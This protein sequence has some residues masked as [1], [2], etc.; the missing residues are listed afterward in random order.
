M[1]IRIVDD[2]EDRDRY[3]WISALLLLVLLWGLAEWFKALPRWGQVTVLM[4][5]LG[6]GLWCSWPRDLGGPVATYTSADVIS[7]CRQGIAQC[8]P[9]WVR[10]ESQPSASSAESSASLTPASSQPTPVAASSPPVAPEVSVPSEV[11]TTAGTPRPVTSEPSLR[12]TMAPDGSTAPMVNQTSSPSQPIGTN[13]APTE[14]NSAPQSYSSMPPLAPPINSVSSERSETQAKRDEEIRTL[15]ERLQSLNANMQTSM[16]QTSDPRPT[17][18]EQT[19]A[20]RVYEQC[21]MEASQIRT[22]LD[23]LKARP[24]Y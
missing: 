12:G 23:A 11:S 20:G 10:P 7:V 15:T 1:T 21:F 5:A 9:N 3:S 16:M 19:R 14:P 2:R 6:V 4:L 13:W 17:A 24:Q 22:K 8:M 18:V